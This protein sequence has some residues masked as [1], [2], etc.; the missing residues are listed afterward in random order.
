M[1]TSDVP[2]SKLYVGMGSYKPFTLEAEQSFGTMRF[3]EFL[4]DRF[5]A[6]VHQ[7]GFRQAAV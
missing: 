3:N 6:L 2:Y 7:A 1:V 5:M 4:S